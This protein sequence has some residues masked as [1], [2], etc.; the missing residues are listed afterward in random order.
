MKQLRTS[1]HPSHVSED[2][3]QVL[4]LPASTRSDSINVG[5][6]SLIADHA[7]AA[8]LSAAVVDLGHYELPLYDGDLEAR[9][10]VPDAARRLAHRIARVDTLVLVSPEY[11]G[12]FTPLLK[13]T[14][15]WM[16][17][18]DHGVLAHLQVA[19]ASASPGGGG[20]RNGLEMIRHWMHNMAV[21]VT[22]ESLAIGSAEL[23]ADGA[24]TGEGLDR[25]D[26]F[27]SSFVPIARAA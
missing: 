7:T 11:N 21:S 25:L 23:D 15:D 9:H 17:R 19:L 12:S 16:T 26:G 20:G 5:L 10:G 6:A 14:V 27:V 24:L 8:G 22:A 13:N 4:V 1:D 18:I 3:P 2:E